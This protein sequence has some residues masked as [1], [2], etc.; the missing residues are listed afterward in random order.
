M[1][2]M[3]YAILSDLHANLE[4]L[5]RALDD[6]AR[7]GV[8][9]VVSLGDSVGYGPLPAETL[10]RLRASAALVLAGNHDDA[11]SGRIKAEDFIELAGDAV[12]RHRDAL[13]REAIAY[14][15]TLP[16]TATI[17]GAVLAHADLTDPAAFNY[18][19]S[20]DAAAAN[21]AATDAALVFVGHTHEPGLYLTG[22]SGRIYR[23]G[24]E[25]FACEPG[26]RYI[27]N[28]GSVGYP[29]E[30]NG[31]CHS[32]Y[33]IYD[34]SDGTVR[35][36]KIPFAVASVLQRGRNRAPRR[37]ALVALGALLLTV[38]LALGALF[39]TR[40]QTSASLPP[41]FSRTVAFDGGEKA[42]RAHL[43]LAKGSP[44]AQL[45]IVFFDAGEK[46]L[47]PVFQRVV[48]KNN[49]AFKIPAGAVRARV[50]VHPTAAN[51]MV[52]VKAFAPSAE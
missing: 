49:T 2:L 39:F 10:A 41:V 16:Y 52:K 42:V 50:S 28:V 30:A 51:A 9:T 5:E 17:E 26:K 46:P 20:E 3:R 21:F 40:A 4:A 43:E 45:Q 34:S 48:L 27:V 7:H 14:L 44:A 32:T 6:A 24:P 38:G 13:S 47:P 1:T 37:K 22:Q 36:R 8:E 11:V 35:F 15:R 18:I 33:V 25:D 23:L 12:S 29:R 31:T 19:D